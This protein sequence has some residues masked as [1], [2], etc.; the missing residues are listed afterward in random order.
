MGMAAS[1]A[2]YLALVARK[3]N[4]EYE[5]QQIN[6]ARTALSNQSANLFNQMLGLQVPVPPSTQDFTKVQY[7]YTDGVNASTIENWQQLAN[8]PDYNYVVTHYYYTDRYTGSLKKLTDPQVQF[9]NASATFAT[10]AQIQQAL[11]DID[12]TLQAYE[13]AKAATAAAQEDILDASNYSTTIHN[14]V[15]ATPNGNNYVITDANGNSTT[16]FSLAERLNPPPNTVS[17]IPPGPKSAIDQILNDLINQGVLTGQASDHY[18]NIYYDM[19]GSSSNMNIVFSDDLRNLIGASAGGTSTDLITYN[20]GTVSARANTLN[21][22]LSAAKLAEATAAANYTN[23]VNAYNALCVPTHIGNCELTPLSTLSI[24]QLAE[25]NQVIE[26]LRAEGIDNEL[27][28]CFDANGNYLGGIYSFSLGGITYYTTLEDLKDSYS[29]GT[30]INNIDGQFKLNYYNATYIKTKIEE[31]EKALLETDGNGRFSSVRFQNDS[32][33]YI[34]NMETVTDE[35]AY[36]DAMNQYVY[37]SAKYDKMIQDI[38]ARTSIIHQQDQQLELRL[39]Q[40]DTEQNALSTEMEAVQKIVQNNV[41][42]T[43]KT[44]NG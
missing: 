34:L 18:N 35:A 15:S 21:A 4:C 36:D 17:P 26:D 30:G 44:F 12:T 43:F 38:N 2:R 13:Q 14:I 33:T 31:T 16:Y 40:L 7:S 28:D 29:S 19:N 9:E 20:S 8:D 1:Q 5:G 3:S 6:Q 22:T 10:A 11:T 39:K 23:A 41:K 37:E 25:I 32:I 42:D 27:D 24:D